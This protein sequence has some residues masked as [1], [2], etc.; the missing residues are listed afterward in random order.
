MLCFNVD[1]FGVLSERSYAAYTVIG[2]WALTSDQLLVGLTR[3]MFPF[4]AGLL[5]SRLHIS[6]SVR[7]G[8]FAIASVIVAA[9]LAMPYYFAAPD[10]PWQ[11]GAYEAFAILAVFP[12]VVALGAGCRLDPGPGAKLCKALGELSYPLYVTHLPLVYAKMAWVANHPKAT[13]G[14]HVA[15]GVSVFVCA[16]AIAWASLKLFDLPVRAWLS[17]RR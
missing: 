13:V 9:T 5:L 2:G 4:F 1:P 14:Q 15:L 11:N 3:L 8:G 16:I 12:F 7:R 17:R 10:A 6:V